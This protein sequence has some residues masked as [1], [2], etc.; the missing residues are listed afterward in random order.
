MKEQMLVQE[1]QLKDV[2][3]RCQNLQQQLSHVQHSLTTIIRY[4]DH[5]IC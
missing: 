2:S 1:H 5:M 4:V 3:L